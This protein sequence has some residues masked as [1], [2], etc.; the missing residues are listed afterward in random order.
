VVVRDRAVQA[1]PALNE[2]LNYQTLVLDG[3]NAEW[4]ISRLL[5]QDTLGRIHPVTR[6]GA[7]QLEIK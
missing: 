2:K 4:Y 7:F 3:T 1:L 6:K 5:E